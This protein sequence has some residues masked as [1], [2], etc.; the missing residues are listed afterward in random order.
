MSEQQDKLQVAKMVKSLF[1]TASEFIRLAQMIGAG[2]L[3]NTESN[4]DNLKLVKTLKA[5]LE[6][7]AQERPL[8]AKILEFR[9]I[10]LMSVEETAERVGYKKTFIYVKQRQAI[11]YL[12][13]RFFTNVAPKWTSP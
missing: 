11:E 6:K 12:A 7:L 1:I 13:L 10:D 8:E 5:Y 4:R 2:E 3:K 9:Y